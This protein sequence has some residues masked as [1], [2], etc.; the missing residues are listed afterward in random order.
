MSRNKT[1]SVIVIAA[2]FVL[3]FC[4]DKPSLNKLDRSVNEIK[5]NVTHYLEN[6]ITTEEPV[7]F[8][9]SKDDDSGKPQGHQDAKHVDDGMT[10]IRDT[11]RNDDEFKD[12]LDEPTTTTRPERQQNSR[13]QTLD[14]IDKYLIEGILEIID[15]KFET[16][17][18]RVMT[19]ERGINNLQ[20]YNVRSFRV[21][22]TH[23]HAVDTILHSLHGQVTITENQNKVLE[24]E[25]RTLKHDLSD[26]HSTNQGMFQAIEQNLAFYH[27]DIQN[28]LSEV[29]REMEKSN[30][31]IDV[32]RNET[33]NIERE[34]ELLSSLQDETKMKAEASLLL[35][36]DIMQVTNK[37][38]NET[39][40][41]T[42]R[43]R[44]L[45]IQ[46]YSINK[47]VEG[48][49]RNVSNIARDTDQLKNSIT[50][51]QANITSNIKDE[52][53][54]HHENVKD[55]KREDVH[56][57]M[58]GSESS[59]HISCAKVLQMLEYL[60]TT[61]VHI[62]T[63]IA[64]PGQSDKVEFP[65]DFKNE[66][67]KLLYALSTVND[68]V[69]QSV[70]LYRHTGN[71]IERLVSNF[72]TVNEEQ[73]SLREDIMNY[74][75]NGTLD[76]FN[77][78]AP[79]LLGVVDRPKPKEP[80]QVDD[81][82]NTCSIS[83]AILQEMAQI[84]KNGSDLVEVLTDIATSGSGA[85]KE[86]L[87]RFDRQLNRLSKMSIDS[88]VP[89]QR[90]Q[91]VTEGFAQDENPNTLQ[92]AIQDIQNKTDLVYRFAEAIASNTGWIPFV[93]HRV[94]F[95]E[96]QVNKSLNILTNMDSRVTSIDT[97]TSELFLRQ[98]ANLAFLFKPSHKTT[99]DQEIKA[100]E[101]QDIESSSLKQSGQLDQTASAQS[102][103]EATVT[104]L[105][106]QSVEDDDH[107][108]FDNGSRL[109]T[110]LDEPRGVPDMV[111][112]LYRTIKKFSRLM[113]ALTL[114]LAE[115]GMTQCVYS[116]F[117]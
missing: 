71:L 68:N 91:Q 86:S 29:S 107:G 2:C 64:N 32:V 48:V 18:K 112:F 27:A 40:V 70:T 14:P 61:V 63:N 5:E 35:G 43:T 100:K 77:R 104:A 9:K 12:D 81:T 8:S 113:P 53:L 36:K 50:L 37:V 52:R 6:T 80:Q 60:N 4:A 10:D 74:L 87:Q 21:V 16:L 13:T 95:V 26:L 108:D 20:Y 79:D 41:V 66:S 49:A 67:S 58:T 25:A 102:Q 19:L 44:D 54:V 84:S 57:E 28:R 76:L 59:M 31:Q 3:V 56:Q 11:N 101:K 97:H 88:P 39:H 62:K 34:I 83:K 22:N 46:S 65:S 30:A 47:L 38:L 23:L 69:Y 42:E 92:V 98:R 115:P 90:R 105:P 33:S 82:Q 45:E 93:Y 1:K 85:L 73:L 109:Y 78:S 94:K 96:N 106:A 7:N 15:E 110:T 111:S 103:L 75:L 17:N 117:H 89:S 99:N 72:E 24:E 114:F 55:T 51:F 116:R